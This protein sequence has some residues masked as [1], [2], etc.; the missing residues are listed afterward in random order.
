MPI[1]ILRIADLLFCEKGIKPID[2]YLTI[3]P[4][5]RMGSESIALYSAG[6]RNN[7]FSKRKPTS[8]S[9]ISRQT[10]QLKLAK[11]DS[12]TIVLVFKAG[13]FRYW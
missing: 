5:A 4:R 12:A 11:R 9:K 1:P 7:W 6:E 3:I 13:A 10:E 2:K 8:W